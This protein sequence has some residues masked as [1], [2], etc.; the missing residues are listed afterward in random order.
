MLVGL[1]A[2]ASTHS[3]AYPRPADRRGAVADAAAS[4]A[5]RRTAYGG[6]E[7]NR[8]LLASP[9]RRSGEAPH[10]K[11]ALEQAFV[12]DGLAVLEVRARP[13]ALNASDEGA[14]ARVS[15]LRTTTRSGEY[16]TKCEPD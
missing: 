9:L 12:Q 1:S 13:G 3:F 6:D 2:S 8:S 14:H 5:A 15:I 11:G 7:E 10:I 16:L 4:R